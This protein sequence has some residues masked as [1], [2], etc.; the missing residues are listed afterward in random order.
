MLKEGTSRR[1]KMHRKLGTLIAEIAVS[2]MH[3]HR[4]LSL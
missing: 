4:G 2:S 1:Y 3:R